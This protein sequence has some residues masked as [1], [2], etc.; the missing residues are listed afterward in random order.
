MPHDPAKYLFDML[1]SCRFLRC[2]TSQRTLE[3]FRTD[4]GFRSAVER[5]LQIIGEALY[6][7]Q[8]IAPEIAD[9]VSEGHRIIGLRHRLVHG[10]GGLRS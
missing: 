2:F 5:E 10:Y 1:D 9:R 8:G 4:R 7:L 6:Q 3:E